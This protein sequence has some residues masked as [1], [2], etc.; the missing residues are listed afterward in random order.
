M[1]EL[2]NFGRL[3]R[4]VFMDVSAGVTVGSALAGRHEFAMR[5]SCR[6]S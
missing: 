3:H 6:L 1:D 5:V 4:W 2:D